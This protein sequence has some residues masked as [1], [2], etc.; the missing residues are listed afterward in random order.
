MVSVLFGDIYSEYGVID[1][2]YTFDISAWYLSPISLALK[3][4]W[5]HPLGGAF[6][7]LIESPGEI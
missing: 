4:F 5:V 1:A 7:T 3:L 2:L 6:S